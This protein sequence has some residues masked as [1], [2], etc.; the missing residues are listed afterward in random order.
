MAQF[1]QSARQQIE[2]EISELRKQKQLEIVQWQKQAEANFK[3]KLV[4]LV[5][6]A[7]QKVLQREVKPKDEQVLL[8]ALVNELDE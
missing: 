1:R 2:D 4:N 7:T 5:I 6:L 8:T 3:E